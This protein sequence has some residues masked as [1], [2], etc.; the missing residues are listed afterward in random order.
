MLLQVK[1]VNVWDNYC[2][3]CIKY[4]SFLCFPQ[5][6]HCDHTH[7]SA[8]TIF[9]TLHLLWHT[10]AII[11]GSCA[12]SYP[13]RLFWILGIQYGRQNTHLFPFISCY[14]CCI[15]HSRWLYHIYYPLSC[16]EFYH[17]YYP[18]GKNCNSVTSFCIIY[19][20]FFK[21]FCQLSF[22]AICHIEMHTSVK[23]LFP[24]QYALFNLGKMFYS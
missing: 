7:F 15:W 6:I 24:P 9:L 4:L 5:I 11:L 12:L 14:M 22:S 10:L 19:S 23:Q 17:V 16:W 21:H 2:K 20:L 18:T 1:I 3:Y 8:L 13:N